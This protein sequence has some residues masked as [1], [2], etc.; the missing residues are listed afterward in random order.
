ML[1]SA[2]AVLVGGAIGTAARAL[3]GEAVP[4]AW[5]LVAVNA[6]GSFL[7]GVAAVAAA[8][9]PAWL[10]HGVGAGLLGGFTT[11]SAVALASVTATA[12]GGGW[13]AVVPALPGIALAA[14]HLVAS[15]AAAWSGLAAG[16]GLRRRRAA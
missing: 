12:G 9:A 6:L 8:D 5:M 15:L 2:L 14:A 11:F 1:P 3:L 10:R 4:D 13:A 16:R 7:L